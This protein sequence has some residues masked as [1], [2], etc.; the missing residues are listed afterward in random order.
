MLRDPI[1]RYRS[2]ISRLTTRRK[3]EIARYRGMARG[4]YSSVLQPWEAEYA[5]SEVLVLQFEACLADPGE[6]LATTFRFLGVDDTFRPPGM[7]NAV[8]KTRTK[9]EVDGD[10]EKLL[11]RLYEPEVVAVASKYPQLD[12]RLWPHF[13]HLADEPGFTVSR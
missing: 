2:D 9:R 13:A 8:N 11:V 7:L 12:L 1:E 3:L 4:F 6:M 5:D 10:I